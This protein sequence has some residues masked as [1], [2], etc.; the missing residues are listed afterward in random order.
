MI[1]NDHIKPS[2]MQILSPFYLK[3]AMKSLLCFLIL[4]L[5]SASESFAAPEEAP[6]INASTDENSHQEVV[7]GGVGKDEKLA[8][9]DA[10]RNA[11]EQVVGMVLDS[12]VH[13][14]N[15]KIIADQI[16]TASD[17]FV[18]EY[19]LLSSE[20]EDGLT[21]VRIKAKIERKSL[22]QK[23]EANQVVVKEVNMDNLFAKVASDNQSAEDST[24]LIAERIKEFHK[25]WAATAGEPVYD[26][27]S[28][29]LS[30]PL[31]I[32]EC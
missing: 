4:A 21:R 17:G 1:F 13:A 5:A 29:T 14:K 25:V 10:F 26:R 28:G 32:Y 18:K 23:L 2:K 24:L 3:H 15:D 31:T 11:V 7:A 9:K 12:T 22:V 6:P 16:L 20:A 27:S 30:I 19:K 8:L